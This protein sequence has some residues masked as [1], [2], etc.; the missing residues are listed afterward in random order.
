MKIITIGTQ[1]TLYITQ[2]KLIFNR[3]MLVPNLKKKVNFSRFDEKTIL[4]R[5]K[6]MLQVFFEIFILK[7]KL[8]EILSKV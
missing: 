4:I 6:K 7:K 1:L 5:K 3:N 2:I 8:S